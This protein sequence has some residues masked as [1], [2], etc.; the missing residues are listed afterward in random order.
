MIPVAP[1]LELDDP[2]TVH[3]LL[4]ARGLGDVEAW[5]WVGELM[6]RIHAARKIDK[7]QVISSYSPLVANGPG[8]VLG[9][10]L[11]REPMA[12]VAGYLES[13]TEF[14]G[15]D[16]PADREEVYDLFLLHRQLQ[17]QAAPGPVD[18]V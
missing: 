13:F 5:R 7:L 1:S 11:E 12:N 3:L 18:P 8:F 9:V 10:L 17:D 6:P 4:K 2:R 15:P 14:I 16:I